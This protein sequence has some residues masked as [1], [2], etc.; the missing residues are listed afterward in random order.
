[1]TGEEETLSLLGSETL[2]KK[3]SSFELARYKK[4]CNRH[5]FLNDDHIRYCNNTLDL[6]KELGQLNT[7]N[8]NLA[9]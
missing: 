5:T 2:D 4:D 6:S 9:N 8:L 7:T 3:P 1:M